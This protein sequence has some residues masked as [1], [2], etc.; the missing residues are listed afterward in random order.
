MSVFFL[1]GSLGTY[2]TV[3]ANNMTYG[4][5]LEGL[6]TYVSQVSCQSLQCDIA[7]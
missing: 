4:G 6:E 1:L 7:L 2:H 3:Y 5:A